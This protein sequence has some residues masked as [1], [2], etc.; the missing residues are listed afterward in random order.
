[1][2]KINRINKTL[3]RLFK[4]KRED[5]NKIRNKRATDATKI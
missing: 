3:T 1:M 2:K 4:K 5:P